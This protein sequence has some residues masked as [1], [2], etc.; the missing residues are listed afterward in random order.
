MEYQRAVGPTLAGHNVKIVAATNT[1]ESLEGSPAG[2]R[3]VI[4]EFADREALM[5]WYSSEAYQ[6]VIGLRF[7]ATEGFGMV[8]E[9]FK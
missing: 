3:M 8:V 2:S 9:G 7:A 1:A 4:M 5:A 6:Q